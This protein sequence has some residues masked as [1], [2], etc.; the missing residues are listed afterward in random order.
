MDRNEGPSEADIA[1]S[2]RASSGSTGKW[3]ARAG[4]VFLLLALLSLIV[5]A[6]VPFLQQD[7][8]SPAGMPAVPDR[9]RALV[10]GVIDGNTIAVEIEGAA[11][12]VRYLGVDLPP[13]GD[14]WRGWAASV[15]SRWVAGKTVLVERDATDA[16][17]DGRLLRY[18][19]VD[20]LFVNGALLAVGLG[21]HTDRYPDPRYSPDLALYERNARAEKLGMWQTRGVRAVPGGA[22]TGQL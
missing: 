17:E 6:I 18:V 1:A 20:D 15:N 10:T 21:S 5:S 22:A 11:Y 2:E 9:S 13:P 12:E 19:W 3:L 4:L 8:A 7:G 16:D 14:P